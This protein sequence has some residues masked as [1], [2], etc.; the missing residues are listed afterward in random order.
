MAKDRMETKAL[1]LCVWLRDQSEASGVCNE[2]V[3][4][5]CVLT[6]VFGFVN[7]RVGV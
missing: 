4:G 1:L 7:I 6:C 3:G 5:L 2:C